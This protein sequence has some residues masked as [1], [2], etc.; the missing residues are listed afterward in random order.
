M[1]KRIGFIGLGEMGYPMALN[2][3]NA[4]YRLSAYDSRREPLLEIEKH[5]AIIARSPK[6]VAQSS[7]IVI[8]MVLTAS[9]VVSV[10]RGEE[11]AL[12]GANPGMTF[13]IM[14]TIEPRI[15]QELSELASVKGINILDAPVSGA[16]RGAEEGTLSIIVGGPKAVFEECRPVFDALGK[17][18][19][20]VGDIGMGEAAKLINNHLVLVNMLAV[21]EAMNLAQAAGVKTDVLL[22]LIK[23]STGNSWVIENWDL[24][25]SWKE[26]PRLDRTTQITF[27]DIKTLYK[28]IQ[29]TLNFARDLNVPLQLAGLSSQLGWF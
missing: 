5:G 9:Q 11:G 7:D 22:E 6:E 16:K 8:C 14:S 21:Y 12:E 23:K 13:L 10:F 1:K 15:V 19:F 4:G 17:N 28:D 27:K 26:T 25:K 29:I 3:L 24:V 2:L 18:I 20:Y